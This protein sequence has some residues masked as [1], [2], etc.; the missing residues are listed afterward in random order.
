MLRFYPDTTK[1]IF[2]DLEFY[3]PTADRKR[4]SPRGMTYSPMRSG[5]KILGGTF[6]VFFPMTGAAGKCHSFWEWEAGSE[7]ATLGLIFSLLEKEWRALEKKENAGSLMLCGIGISH[8]DVPALLTKLIHHAVSS[9]ERIY[10]VLCGCRQIDLIAAT[11]C[12]R[13]PRRGVETAS[14]R[15]ADTVGIRHVSWRLPVA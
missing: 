15:D 13:V 4:P 8:S 10:D 5:H 12:G 11:L 7:Q 3:V 14:V 9:K 1:I 6:Q 2:F